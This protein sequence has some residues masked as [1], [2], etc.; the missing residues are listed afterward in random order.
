[1][2]I[3][4]NLIIINIHNLKNKIK[5]SLIN[6]INIQKNK[7]PYKKIK[8]IIKCYNYIK[9]NLNQ[10]ILILHSIT[11]MILLNTNILIY[12]NIL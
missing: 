5:N 3:K 11:I 9:Y 7:I 4:N 2:T 12:Y 10:T 6:F 1:M 8:Y